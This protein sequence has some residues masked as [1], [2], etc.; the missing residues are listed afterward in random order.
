MELRANDIL[1]QFWFQPRNPQKEKTVQEI[2]AV[3]SQVNFLQT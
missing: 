1:S 2:P 3:L